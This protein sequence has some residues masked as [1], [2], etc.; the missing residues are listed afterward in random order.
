MKMFSQVIRMILL[1]ICLLVFV[2]LLEYGTY[3]GF[4]IKWDGFISLAA[5]GIIRWATEM[6]INFWDTIAWL[7]W[8]RLYLSDW[9]VCT[10]ERYI[11]ILGKWE[12]SENEDNYRVKYVIVALIFHLDELM[13]SLVLNVNLPQW[14]IK[15]R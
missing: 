7:N 4:I 13:C 10:L 8:Q 12:G 1:V 5:I 6:G 3:I 9:Q 15:G 14:R 11:W 2:Y